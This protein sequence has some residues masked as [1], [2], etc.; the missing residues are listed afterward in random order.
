MAWL[1]EKSAVWR[2]IVAVTAASPWA[3]AGFT[4]ISLGAAYY[5]GK[6][7]MWLTEKDP[8]K[9]KQ[10]LAKHDDRMSSQMMRRVN[11]ERL[12]VLLGEVEK[13]DKSSDRW[14]AALRGE[15]LGTHSRGTT[16]GAQGVRPRDEAPPPR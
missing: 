4:G 13:G 11:R 15:S 3:M 14:A 12:A 6:G 7:F 5:M 8:E 2:G 10:Q 16:T 9:A 1:Y